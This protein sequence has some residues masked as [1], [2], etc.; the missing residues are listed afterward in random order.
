M[1]LRRAEG[2]TTW[3]PALGPATIVDHEEI[4]MFKPSRAGAIALAL[5]SAMTLTCCMRPPTTTPPSTTTT[6]STA[7]PSG[8]GSLSVQGGKLLDGRGNQI[9]LRGVNHAHTWYTSQ[10]AS[11]LPAIKAAG[12]N[13]VRVVLAGGARSDW[14]KSSAS[15][16]AS[17][18]SQCRQ[19][20]LIC[21]LEDHDTT[22]YG[23]DGK[24]GT[25]AAAASYFASLASV[26]K[27][28]ENFVIIN[29]GNEPYGTND[30]RWV[31]DTASAIRTI[32]A[33]GLKHTLMVD[34]PGWGQDSEGVMRNN[35]STILGTDRNV[36]FSVHMYEV[37]G[38][39]QTVRS[40]IDSFTSQGLPLV[41]G[42][43][44]PQNNGKSV[45]VETIL[46]YTQ[47]KGVGY[48]AWSWSGNGSCC[49]GLDL[50][51]NFNASSPTSWGN[52]LINGANGLKATSREAN[53]F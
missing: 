45:D 6:P 37:Y 46:S 51:N 33:A 39:G 21:V 32:R 27:G 26:L 48:L 5:I 19:N 22:G 50:V 43:F 34:A 29:I 15:D 23:S 35:T 36:L 49:P 52:R 42:E 25:L 8:T 3:P 4:P 9:I 18:V 53:V 1:G 41:V 11:A 2:R 7:P 38:S 40:Y 16:V 24:A 12:A 14:T 10:T 44:G 13:S 17:V 28:Q 30:S 20:R 47:A 31:S